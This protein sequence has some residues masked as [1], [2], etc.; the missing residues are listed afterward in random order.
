[1]LN[2]KKEHY[3]SINCTLDGFDRDVEDDNGEHSLASNDYPLAQENVDAEAEELLDWRKFLLVVGRAGIGKS[4]ALVKVI[5]ACISISA[6]AF[7]ATPTG[8]LATQFKDKFL[9]D[10]D[11]NTIHAAFQYPV[12]AKEQPRY[13]WNLSNYDLIVIDK[14]SMVPVKIFEHILAMISELPIR[15]ILL[16]AGDDSKL[17]PI[18]KVDDKI[19]LT[20]MAMKC[21]QVPVTTNKIIL[22]EQHRNDDDDY[23][24][25]LNHIRCWR[26]SQCLLDEIQKDR[27]FF[28]EQPSDENILQALID[29]P[30]STVITVSHS[31]P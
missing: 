13:N 26:P 1:M 21:T 27:L 20:K 28:H 3:A 30:H 9:E 7:V 14:L 2:K 31:I 11:A 4:F 12:L 17:Q 25:F 19:K 22:T 29:H 8:F 23:A 16:L 18:E 10:I 6:N 15:P 24:K 5:D